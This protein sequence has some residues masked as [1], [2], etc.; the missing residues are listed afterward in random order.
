MFIEWLIFLSVLAIMLEASVKTIDRFRELVRHI[1]E[2]KV[3]ES[4]IQKLELLALSLLT[5]IVFGL[6]ILDVAALTVIPTLATGAFGCILT[7]LL[8]GRGA[9][10]FH[11]IV[12]KILEI[13]KLRNTDA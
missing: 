6:N 10:V 7:G 3:E 1:I 11:G 12:E 2:K 5:T 13:I 8:I 9:N 4:D